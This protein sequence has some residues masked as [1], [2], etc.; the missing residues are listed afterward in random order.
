MAEI[1]ENPNHVV[2]PVID[3]ISDKTLAYNYGT[4]Y[5]FQIGSFTWAGHFTWMDMDEEKL[6]ESPTKAVSSPTMAGGLL[7]INRNY[8]F[9]IG[10]YD[11]AMEIWGGENLEMSFRIWQC[12]GKLSIHPCSHVGHIF[13][14]Y[15]PY[16]FQG[17][18]THGI[19]TLRTMMVWMDPEYRRYFFMHRT[20]LA[21]INPGDLT[22]RL[23][24]KKR[25]KCKSFKWYLD[26]IFE[27][28][29]FI[30]DQNAQAWGTIRNRKSGLCLDTLNENEEKSY[31]LGVF[32]C[33]QRLANQYTNQFL[34]LTNDG[35]LRRDESCA[36]ATG[37][38]EGNVKMDKCTIVEF[39]L[40]KSR[41]TMAHE[42]KKQK[43]KHLKGGWIVNVGTNLCLTTKKLK[44]M[45]KIKLT[46]CNSYDPYQKWRFQS[47]AEV[48]F[49]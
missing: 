7:A 29:K 19:N 41:E 17:K 30:Y 34:T 20:D 18:D 27:G 12:G 21:D 35:E 31:P 45:S 40:K 2:C 39:G 23:E 6:I 10:S 25:L 16:S 46:K 1:A 42:K 13:R 14:D 48:D 44:S 38:K 28:R 22:D 4:P 24:L 15:H 36:T 5:F 49:I 32:H 8:F 47:Y 3:V 37:D 33:E 11:E 43:W 9:S 26:N